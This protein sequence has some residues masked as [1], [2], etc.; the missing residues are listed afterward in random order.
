MIHRCFILK[1]LI[2]LK[3]KRLTNKFIKTAKEAFLLHWITYFPSFPLASGVSAV[4]IF[5][6]DWS[7]FDRFYF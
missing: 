1:S 6:A 4:I 3:S 2:V 7:N 5:L